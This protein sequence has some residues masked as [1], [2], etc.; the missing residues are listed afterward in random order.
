MESSDFTGGNILTIPYFVLISFIIL[1]CC[2]VVK[3]HDTIICTMMSSIVMR[4]LHQSL[5]INHRVWSNKT[6]LMPPLFIEVPVPGHLSETVMH[7]CIMG[8]DVASFLDCSIGFWNCSDS[9]VF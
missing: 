8:I 4:Y 6:S 5:F 2:L 9:V 1:D 7:L 3:S